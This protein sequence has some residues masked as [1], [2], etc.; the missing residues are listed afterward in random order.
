MTTALCE[1]GRKKTGRKG[2]KKKPGPKRGKKCIYGMK[3]SGRCYRKGAKGSHKR[4]HGLKKAHR[5]KGKSRYVTV[6]GKKIGRVYVNKKGERETLYFRPIGP[7]NRSRKPVKVVSKKSISVAALKPH[8][9]RSAR[10]AG[11]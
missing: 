3:S 5:T 2:C 9:R 8:L 11:K 4:R 7:S 6:A 10:L 1:R